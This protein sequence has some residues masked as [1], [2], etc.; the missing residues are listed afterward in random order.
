MVSAKTGEGVE[1]M[2]NEICQKLIK[3]AAMKKKERDQTKLGNE[4]EK[5][6]KKCC[7]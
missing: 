2:F 1:I 6:K 4:A 3:T 5:K 7:G